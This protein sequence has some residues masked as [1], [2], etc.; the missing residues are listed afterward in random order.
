MTIPYYFISVPRVASNSVHT[1]LQSNTRMYN[2][3]TASHMVELVGRK[4]WDKAFTFGGVRHPLDRLV[5][6]F[7]WCNKVKAGMDVS[8][9]FEQ[10]LKEGCPHTMEL[11]GY[12]PGPGWS[13][14]LCD[15]LCDKA[16]NL[17]VDFV[18][19]YEHL[20]QDFNQICRRIGRKPAKLPR[21]S[22]SGRK[23]GYRQWYTPKLR[24][25]A[26]DICRKDL[27]MFYP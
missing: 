10:W 24:T 8:L 6:W 19:R 1:A 17:L 26:E 12:H 11:M 7:K 15:F 4:A 3:A 9:N 20:Q 22:E 14:S 25:L 5:S 13:I 21:M 27:E 2:H 16:G 18:Y 23:V